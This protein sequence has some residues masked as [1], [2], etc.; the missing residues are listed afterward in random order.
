M[1]LLWWPDVQSLV[2]E[3]IEF[4]NWNCTRRVCSVQIGWVKTACA[5]H[6]AEPA[7]SDMMA[8][9]NTPTDT[10]TVELLRKRRARCPRRVLVCD[11]SELKG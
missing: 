1:P 11:G 6:N 5:K 7:K 10:R 9:A 8:C 3:P 4:S 2:A